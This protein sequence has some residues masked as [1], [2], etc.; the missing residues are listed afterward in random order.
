MIVY[1]YVIDEYELL[2]N[3]MKWTM[4][5]GKKNTYKE[6]GFITY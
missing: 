4:K 5:D 2:G 1:D 6:Y 3:N